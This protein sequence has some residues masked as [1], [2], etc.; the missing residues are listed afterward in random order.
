MDR[1]RECMLAVDD[2]RWMMRGG[3]EGLLVDGELV[4]KGGRERLDVT[5]SP[6][7]RDD[8]TSPAWQQAESNA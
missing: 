4:V 5:T 6:R 7:G 1:E 3:G 8:I 2:E